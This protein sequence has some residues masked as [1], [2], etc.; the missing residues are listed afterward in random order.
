ME[1]GVVEGYIDYSGAMRTMT[2]TLSRPDHKNALTLAMYEQLSEAIERASIDGSVRALLL[3]GEEGCFTAGNDLNDFARASQLL[4]A[5]NPIVR[6]L[7]CLRDFPK[8]IVV[9]VDGVAVGIGTTLLLHSD[10]VFASS[11][12]QFRLPFV[13]L[14]LSPEYASSL[15]LP[16]LVGHARASELLL[17]GEFFGAG[18]AIEY[19]LINS[20]TEAPLTAAKEACM[21]LSRQAPEAVRQAKSLLKAPA[22]NAVK[23]VMQKEFEVFTKRLQSPEF[24]EAATAFFEKRDPDFSSFE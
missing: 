14:G 13:N 15:L 17:L 22:Q 5:E 8:P 20:V 11:K 9:A 18:K 1:E 4:D 21:K 3:A 7:E 23:E 10:L 19:G 6:F 2:L 16:R 12:A 24:S